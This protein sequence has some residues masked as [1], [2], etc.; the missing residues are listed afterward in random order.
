MTAGIENFKIKLIGALAAV[1]LTSFTATAATAEIQQNQ[2]SNTSQSLDRLMQT[3][4]DFIIHDYRFSNGQKLDM[5]KLHYATLGTPKKDAS[6]KISN[7]VLM[8]HWTGADGAA[9]LSDDF[10]THL[11]APGKP[12]DATKYFLIFPDSI[13]HGKSSKPSD[14]LKSDFP[15]YGYLDMVDLQHKLVVDGLGISHLNIVLGTSM[16]GMHTWLWSV[17]YPTFMD[18]VMP[19]VSLPESH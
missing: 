11:Y 2:T 7:A 12:L 15:A 17:L 13:G 10:K 4:N 1:I 3:E 6:G 14:G 5:L 18:G 16:G 9:L 8:L 19:I